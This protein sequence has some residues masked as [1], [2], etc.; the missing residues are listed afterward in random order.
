M[1]NN[2]SS[3]W[4]LFGGFHAPSITHSFPKHNARHY[5]VEETYFNYKTNT[6]IKKKAT[7]PAQHVTK[8][9]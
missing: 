7:T 1:G 3:G 2:W 4:E 5:D 8:R 9:L 6:F